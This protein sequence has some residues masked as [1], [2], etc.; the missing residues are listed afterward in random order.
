MHDREEK[1][2]LNTSSQKK[3]QMHTRG[4]RGT[5]MGPMRKSLDKEIYQAYGKKK[6]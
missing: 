3:K 4:H 1:K 2:I 6:G 5:P